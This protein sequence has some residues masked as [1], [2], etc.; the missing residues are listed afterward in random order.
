VKNFAKLHFKKSAAKKVHHAEPLL[1]TI[2]KFP[3][4]PVV[5]FEFAVYHCA[6]RPSTLCNK[7]T[8][9]SG[10]RSTRL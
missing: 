2:R 4:M 5:A 8:I 7:V 3:H 10:G 9:L 1:V 6:Y